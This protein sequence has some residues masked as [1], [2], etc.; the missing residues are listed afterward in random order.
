LVF[1]NN[2]FFDKPIYLLRLKTFDRIGA[3]ANR[4]H[5]DRISKTNKYRQA[6]V[7]KICRLRSSRRY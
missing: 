6:I 3:T 1:I 4:M 5:L 7:M 2:I